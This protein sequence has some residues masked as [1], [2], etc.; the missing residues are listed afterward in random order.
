M[1]ILW[2]SF[3]FQYGN[4]MENS[5]PGV[6]FVF[7]LCYCFSTIMLSFLFSTLFS[8]ANLAAAAGGMLFFLIYVPYPFL[9]MW[10][11]RMSLYKKAGA[12]SVC[13]LLIY[14]FISHIWIYVEVIWFNI[15]LICIG[16]NF[17]RH[18][19]FCIPCIIVI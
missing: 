19:S 6:I 11:D 14:L 13:F 18:A 17:F 1:Y 2:I 7:L 5:N 3:F 15:S 8:R 4:V 12:V 16:F 9:V 10:E